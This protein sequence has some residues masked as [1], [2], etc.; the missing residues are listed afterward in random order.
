MQTLFYFL[1]TLI[2]CLCDAA[3]L[4]MMVRA[5]LSWIPRT[6]GSFERLIYACTEP[7]LFPVRKLFEL[8]DIRPNLP[9]DLSFTVTFVLLVI[10]DGMVTS[11][12]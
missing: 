3:M 12:L 1:A 5:I 8:F 7:L 11:A 10:I 4:L 9:L 2:S 6:G